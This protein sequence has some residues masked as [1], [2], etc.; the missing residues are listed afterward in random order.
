[1]E[2]ISEK[3]AKPSRKTYGIVGDL[4]EKI[5]ELGRKL[6]DIDKKIDN[7]SKKIENKK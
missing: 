3:E 1:M 4:I 5:D 2:V 6:D 7:L